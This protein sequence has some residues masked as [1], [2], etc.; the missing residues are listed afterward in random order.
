MRSSIAPIYAGFLYAYTSSYANKF[1]DYSCIRGKDGTL[2]AE[3]GE[4][5]PRWFFIPE[6]VQEQEK[7]TFYN[8]FGDAVKSGKAK[9]VVDQDEF[10][11]EL[12]PTEL[13]DNSKYHLD[14]WIDCMRAR[15]QKTAGNIHTG[16]AHSIGQIMGTKAYREEKKI[17]W[18][19]NKEEITDTRPA[20]L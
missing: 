8:G 10:K 4:G 16:F 2:F 1:G 18:D 7:F 12:P 17:Y 15:N 5:S 9:L 13:S 20:F 11:G 6:H 19:R 3:G 14:N